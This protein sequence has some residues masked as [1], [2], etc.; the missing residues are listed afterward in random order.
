M[1]SNTTR[2]AKNTLALYFRQIVVMGVS[3]FTVRIV[4]Q[5]LGVIDYGIHNVV[6]GMVA[7]FGFLRT[8]IVEVTQRFLNVEMGKGNYDALQ[9]IFSTSLMLHIIA[10]IL[11]LTV[12]ETVGLWF[13]EN[14]LVIPTERMEAARCVYQFALFG[15]MV[16]M[17]S[18]SFEALIVAHEDMQ[19]Y[20]YVGVF[21]AVA[22]LITAYLLIIAGGDKLKVYAVFN[23][24]VFFI[25]TIFYYKYCQKKYQEAKF[26]FHND[27]ALIKDF[28]RH[29]GYVFVA[30]ALLV[31]RKHGT[32]V[33]LN[34][35]F[36]PVVN[37]ARGL[38]A[39]V[40]NAVLSFRNNFNRAIVPQLTKS[41]AGND[42]RNMWSLLERGTRFSFFLIL[43]FSIPILL[44]TEF[45][46][47]LWLKD[48]P[49]YTSIFVQLVLIEFI[50]V[51]G[52]MFFFGKI[53]NA[54]GK[55][56]AYYS[57]DYVCAILIFVFSY[58]VCKVGY[59]PY[60]VFV[61]SLLIFSLSL[62]VKFIVMKKLVDF[63][64]RFFTQKA[65][66]PMFLVL[67]VS[68]IPFY[69]VNKFVIGSFFQSIVIIVTSPLWT[70][71]VIMYIGM[72]KK[73]RAVVF[74]FVKQKVLRR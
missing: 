71:I 74:N 57:V 16:T 53:V 12:G 13:I 49:E 58:I 50:L 44:K 37:A 8:P 34:V 25:I 72:R 60:Y 55:L 66:L 11:I 48:V 62:L 41:C 17:L 6:G 18:V 63:P 68:F 43:I 64:V 21:E 15:F 23:F 5:T 4:L 52:I 45:I 70:G 54:T 69:I 35:F 10:G 29:I 14:K 73:E 67:A 38:T 31:L 7:M 28:G 2:I 46:L 9:K 40:E 42:R 61:I 3:L 22:K 26:I 51:H 19:I 27:I 47:N 20:G 65:L 36:G 1:P 33:V 24:I 59:A 30:S 39:S 32:S 56:K